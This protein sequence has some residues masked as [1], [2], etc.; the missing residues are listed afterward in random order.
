MEALKR[1]AE[2]LL[3]EL[4]LSPELEP[5]LREAQI[6]RLSIDVR[7]ASGSEVVGLRLRDGRLAA[8]C[9]CGVAG[10]VHARIALKLIAEAPP[11]AQV[12][13]GETRRSSSRLER[14]SLDARAVAALDARVA[15]AR[16]ADVREADAKPSV[17]REAEA[18]P[19]VRSA[20]ALADALDDA[21]TAVVRTGALVDA[22]PSVREMLLRVTHEAGSPLPLGVQRWVGRLRDALDQRN[23]GLAAHALAAASAVSADLRATAHTR[24]ARE[25]LGTWFGTTAGAEVER[26]SDR[27]MLEVSRE[28]LNGTER[29]QIERR[30]L[31]DLDSGETFREE[32][33]RP[34]STLSV[35]SCPRLIGVGYAEIELGCSPRRIQLMQYTTTPSIDRASWDLLTGFG[36]RDSELLAAH[37][38]EALQTFGALS[39]PFS[40]I[41]PRAIEQT[42]EPRVF[43][44]QGPPLGLAVDDESGALKRLLD[45]SAAQPPA[46]LAVRLFDRDQQLLLKPLAAGIVS[47]G[48]LRHERL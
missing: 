29:L 45:V 26:V 25:R 8:H 16:E 21:V 22:S 40:L 32:R 30:Y 18:R 36:Q 28:W 14:V 4:G 11:A 33:A 46:W 47:D 27:L 38:G 37:Y 23:V 9:S 48:A 19:G 2:R 35:G 1:A 5:A 24:Q 3:H 41:V 31:V 44:E 7:L 15:G 43:F 13:S 34:A 39:E 6:D 17:A 42:P 10:C 12:Q 20:T